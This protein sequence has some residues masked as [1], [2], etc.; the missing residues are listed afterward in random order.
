M[1]IDFIELY[2]MYHNTDEQLYD[3]LDYV[4]FDELYIECDKDLDK[5]YEFKCW[6]ED[7]DQY[8]HYN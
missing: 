8:Y 7:V 2:N 6:L 3:K 5:Y 4:D 1:N